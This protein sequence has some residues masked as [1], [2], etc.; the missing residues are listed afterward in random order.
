M[1]SGNPLSQSDY[2]SQKR[3]FKGGRV[4]VEISKE[5]LEELYVKRGLSTW[6]IEKQFGVPRGT[7]YRRL[8]KAGII[9]RNIA[10]SH[11]IYKRKDFSGDLAE[12]AYLIGFR[13]GDLRVRK[14]SKTG[15]TI[16]IECGTTKEEQLDLVKE[17]FQDYGPVWISKKNRKGARN[18]GANLSM[19][20][21]FLLSKFAESWLFDKEE[22]FFPFLAGFTDAE[23]HIGCSKGL[24]RYSLGNY[25]IKLLKRIREALFKFGV[26]CRKISISKRK[27]RPTTEGYTYNADYAILEIGKKFYLSMLLNALKPYIKHKAKIRALDEALENI[28]TRNKR[29]GNIN[30]QL[31]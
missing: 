22:Q 20:F 21:S 2:K 19:S 26:E 24:A 6:E 12:K 10:V 8:K 1:N 5:E 27:G 13:L 18:I 28:E 9:L 7:V 16:S 14:A 30:M 29:F 31:T 17:L 25:D 23:G 3:N 4:K 11:I 15:E